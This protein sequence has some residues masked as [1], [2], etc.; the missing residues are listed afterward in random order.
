MSKERLL[1]GRRVLLVEDEMLVRML[2]EDMLAE[3]GCTV[4]G[5]AIDL[6]QALAL[7]AEA[8]IDIAVLDLNIDGER[9]FAVADTL[10]ARGV[11]FIFATGYASD[12]LPRAHDRV[13][14]LEKPFQQEEL[15]Q[16]LR[17]ALR[18]A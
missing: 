13:V 10:A 5:P 15:G 8:E 14:I 9:S 17:R 7:A 18:Q 2:I 3:L 4:I 1:F 12:G 11:P 16:A 6:E